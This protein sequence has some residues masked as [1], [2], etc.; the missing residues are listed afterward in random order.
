[1]KIY[2]HREA[3]QDA[4]AIEA[5]GSSTV[6]EAF[7]IPDRALVVLVEDAEEP[8]MDVARLEDVLEDRAHVFAGR[9]PRVLASVMFNGVTIEREFSA[10]TRVKRVFAWAVGE[11]GFKLG[12]EDAAEHA[13]ALVSTG[14]M[15]AEDVHLGS[16]DAD[17]PGRVAF[18]LV[19]KH[20]YEG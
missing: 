16:L 15:P 7:G 13:L 2:V 9:R 11:H 4:E 18:N 19:P 10:S 1:M 3:Q 14:A 12:A 20:R 17:T 8:L 6:A 5:E